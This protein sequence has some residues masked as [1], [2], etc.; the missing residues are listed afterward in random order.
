MRASLV[1]LCGE[2]GTQRGLS[3]NCQA[4]GL[5]TGAGLAWFSSAPWVTQP[6]VG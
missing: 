3:G 5:E 6:L 4:G 1:D 2:L